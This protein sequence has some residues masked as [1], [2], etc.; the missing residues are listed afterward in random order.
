MNIFQPFVSGNLSVSGSAEISGS[1]TVNG[2]INAT[3]SGTTSNAQKLNNQP[4]SY[5]AITGSNQFN[6]NQNVSGSVARSEEH[7]SELQSH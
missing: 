5:Y 6:G 2:T 4:A 3:I 1:L 7:T